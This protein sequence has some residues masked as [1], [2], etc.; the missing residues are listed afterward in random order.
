MSDVSS[1][2]ERDVSQIGH[3]EGGKVFIYKLDL[4]IGYTI[5]F[6]ENRGHFENQR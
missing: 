2:I 3:L 6:I 1:K 5:L 4:F